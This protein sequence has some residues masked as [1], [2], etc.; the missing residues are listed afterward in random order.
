[1]AALDHFGVE[2]LIVGGVAVGFH[3]EPRFT[4]D[5]DVLVHVE[6]TNFESLMSALREFGA[7]LHLVKPEDFLRKDFVFFFGSPPWRIDI[8]TSIPGVDF[9]Q[10][11]S[12]R[13]QVK[14]GGV[15]VSCISKK[16][17]ISAKKASGRF[18]DLAD[19]DALTRTEKSDQADS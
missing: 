7:P 18:Q 15:I 8:L 17:L 11:Y 9:R 16:W 1:M 3:A 2:Y 10:A 13:V 14:L 12:E 4:K 5:L 6:P 19:I